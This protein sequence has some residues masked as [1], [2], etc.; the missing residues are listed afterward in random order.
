MCKKKKKKN[1]SQGKVPWYLFLIFGGDCGM[2]YLCWYRGPEFTRASLNL[3]CLAPQI[4]PQMLP[5]SHSQS[6]LAWETLVE[7]DVTCPHFST[8]VLWST[9]VSL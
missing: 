2:P 7:V 6:S 4:L 5:D 9:H 1:Q 8:M 3:D